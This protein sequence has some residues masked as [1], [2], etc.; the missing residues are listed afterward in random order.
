MPQAPLFGGLLLGLPLTRGILKFDMTHE[1]SQDKY[2]TE[3]EDGFLLN[4]CFF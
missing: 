3:N 1:W 2:G 4:T